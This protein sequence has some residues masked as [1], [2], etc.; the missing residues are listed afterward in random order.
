MVFTFLNVDAARQSEFQ[1]CLF[2]ASQLIGSVMGYSHFVL[3]LKSRLE[4]KSEIVCHLCRFFLCS[5]IWLFAFCSL[6]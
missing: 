2:L 5:V 1:L 6:F 3:K 4:V